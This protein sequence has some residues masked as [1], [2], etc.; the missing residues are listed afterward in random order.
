MMLVACESATNLNVSYADA[1]DGGADASANPP[2]FAGCPCD[3]TQGMGCCLTSKGT[4]FCTPSIALCQS[5]DGVW[6]ECSHP[7]LNSESD[8]CWHSGV[9]VKGS[10]TS[11]RTPCDDGGVRAC[12][13]DDQCA[14]G[15][16]CKKKTCGAVEIG[17]CGQDPSCP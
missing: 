8:C 2:E 6:L 10:L 17:A 5:N 12:N 11:Y 9:G 14:A 1:G 15:T 7:A 16:T 4:P 3:T 13:S